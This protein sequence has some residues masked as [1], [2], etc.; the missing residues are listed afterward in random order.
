MRRR[1]G[2]I[3]R[4]RG[5]YSRRIGSRIYNIIEDAIHRAAAG[6]DPRTRALYKHIVHQWLIGVLGAILIVIKVND[7]SNGIEVTQSY[8][9]EVETPMISGN[10]PIIGIGKTC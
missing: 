8:Y 9:P 10:I 5:D 7:T 3:K 1:H 2:R 4:H 6:N